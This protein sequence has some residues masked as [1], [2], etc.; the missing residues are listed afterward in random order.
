[1]LQWAVLLVLGPVTGQSVREQFTQLILLAPFEVFE[2]DSVVLKCQARKQTELGTIT[3]YKNNKKLPHEGNDYQIQHADLKHNGEYHCTNRHDKYHASSNKVKIQVQELFPRPV[4]L[5]RPSQPTDGS[6]VTLTCDTQLSPQ[7]SN[8]QLKFCFLKNNRVLGQGCTRSREYHIPA[9]RKGDSRS[10]TCQAVTESSR[11]R[12]TSHQ[13]QIP[14]QIPVSQPVLTLSTAKANAVERD[15]A[16]LHCEA[17][18]GSPPIW[19]QFYHEDVP[20]GRGTTSSTGGAAFSFS[21]TAE[22]SGKYYCTAKNHLRILRSEAVSLFV[23]VPVSRPVLTLRTPR[24]QA[25]VGDVIELHCEALRGSPP[26]LYQFYHENII[27][28]N[29][30]APS[31][32]G[33]SFNLSLTAEHSGNYLCKANNGGEAQ[34]SDTITLKVTVPVSH[35]GLILR[36]PRAQAVEGDMIELHCEALKGSPPIL[37]QFYHENVTLRSSSPPSGGASFNLFLTEEHSGNYSCEASNVLGAQKS[38]VVTIKVIV[39]VSQPVLTLR[40]PRAQVVVGD[41]VELLCEALRGSPPILYQFYYENITLGNSSA[42]S[43]GGAVFNFSVTEEHSGNYSCEANNSLWAQQSDKVTL[44]ITGLP[45]DRRGSVAAG[46]TGAMLCMVVL[47]AGAL[48]LYCWISR[49]AGE[50]P[51]SDPTRSHSDS[52]PQE[53]TYFNVPGWAELQPVYSNVNSPGGD[54]VYSEVWRTKKNTHAVASEPTVP[55]NQNSPVI[56][57]EVKAAYT[58]A[59]RPNSQPPE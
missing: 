54:V 2:R 52:G 13:F 5:A 57:T 43:G 25:V 20:L 42:P 45:G 17:Q 32:G 49:K 55:A 7:K 28:G 30:S 19:Y 29:S 51:A 26:I 18:E 31:G 39:P 11:I 22:H 15:M 14:V 3:F 8:V 58:P 33:A 59:S 16:T 9:I 6:P 46:L 21:L 41:V 36:M 47:A 35:P 37:Y 34:H 1:M 50:V 27:L 10:Y 53:P 12:K 24:A 4:L 23:T 40:K 44:F 48:L 56:Y 38:E